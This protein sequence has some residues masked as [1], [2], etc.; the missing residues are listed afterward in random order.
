MIK[1]IF[2]GLALICSINAIYAEPAPGRIL[3][4]PK[5]GLP[6]AQLDKSIKENGGLNRKKLNSS[7]NIFIVEVP[8]GSEKSIAARLNNNKHF[9]FAETDESVAPS[10][11]PADPYY[12]NAWHLPKIGM[13]VA[14]DYARGFGVIVAILD[15]G[16]LATH[17]DLA[18]NML[19]GRD[20]V[21][22]TTDSSDLKGHGTSVA[23]TVAAISNNNLGVSSI[24]DK[25]KI[26]PLRIAYDST[27]YAYWSDIAN[28]ITYAANYGARVANNSYAS[29]SSSSVRSAAN[30]LRSKNGLMFI[31]A[32]NDTVEKT[33]TPSND[34]IVVS[35]T[36]QN[37]AK[38]SWSSWGSYVDI[39]APGTGIYVPRY[40]SNSAYGTA[41][42][43]SFSSP[44]AA[45]VVALMMSANPTLPNTQ[46]E[47]LLFST[48]KDIGVV[49][50]DPYFGYGRVDAAAAVIAAKNALPLA[51]T[52]APTVGIVSPI[53][54]ATVSGIIAIDVSY[55]DNVGVTKLELYVNNSLIASDSIIPYGLVWDTTTVVNGTYT[56]AVKAYDAAGNSTLSSNISVKVANYTGTDITPPVLNITSPSNNSYAGMNVQIRSSASDDRGTVQQ[57]LYIDDREV[58]RGTSFISYRWNT[59]SVTSGNHTI[60]VVASDPSGNSTTKSVNVI[61]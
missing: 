5:A 11:I 3:V 17:E 37:D 2:I 44:V 30:Y 43:T 35:A 20:I 13:P 21:N 46:I 1:K 52:T 39:S 61:K 57:I 59:K 33:E 10:F 54:G 27:G 6:E 55:N 58:A 32:G 40:T 42:G 4:S 56:V 18:A 49:G 48:A 34:V 15:T 31:S 60:K 50:K 45:A 14:W 22:N 29:S 47:Q 8:K 25:S 24:S 26:L 51:D 23:G 38:T 7:L 12:S 19:P 53:S 9:K 16:V 41:A 36:D 28:G